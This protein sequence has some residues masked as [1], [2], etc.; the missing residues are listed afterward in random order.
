[1][2]IYSDN[3]TTDVTST[4]TWSSSPS[5]IVTLSG[6]TATA[7]A[8]GAVAITATSGSVSGSAAL[9]VTD[10]TLGNGTLTGNYAFAA[11][12]I[13]SVGPVY[14]AGF[15]T[16]DGNGNITGGELDSNSHDTGAQ[17]A[18]SITGTYSITPDGRGQMTLTATG[19]GTSV[20]FRFVISKDGSKGKLIEFDGLHAIAGTFE[21]QTAG[22]L[23]G[24]YTFR[25]SGL[26]LDS[27]PQY[28]GEVGVV[29]VSGAAL[30]GLADAN[31]NNGVSYSAHT[32]NGTIN[33]PVSS[34]GTM[35]FKLVSGTNVD[36]VYYVVSPSKFYMV[37]SDTGTGSELLAGQ[38]ELQGALATLSGDYTFLL[39]HAATPTTGTF[40]KTGRMTLTGGSVATGSESE[41]LSSS[42]VQDQS[43]A[44]SSGVYTDPTVLSQG[45]GTIGAVVT[46]TGVAPSR[47]FV[48][49]AVDSTKAYMME[50]TANC[51]SP[52]TCSGGAFRAAIGDL[53]GGGSVGLPVLG[54]FIF[55]SVELGELSIGGQNLQIGQLISDG[56]GNL[57]GI[58]DAVKNAGGTATISAVVVSGTP[59]DPV[60]TVL[61]STASCPFEY[62]WTPSNFSALAVKNYLVY[63]RPDGKRAVIL[64]YQPDI[65]GYMDFQ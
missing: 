3:S 15:F 52:S 33:A 6:S 45:R 20:P 41:D 24:I 2:A 48:Y 9:N 22:A 49:Y 46:A 61:C 39:D 37:G 13:D 42:A 31:L 54:D 62:G 58:V 64:G 8:V 55:S 51:G 18:A 17:S 34:R 28:M 53:E 10:L 38:A 25:L 32:F 56:A 14:A 12:G 36:F 59:L 47:N 60:P 57:S 4:A 23:S 7:A 11:Q 1:V 5:G 50:T 65:D 40:E 44:F 19:I 26:E 27:T 35:T 30:N 63:V 21:A 16:S 29:T 43:F